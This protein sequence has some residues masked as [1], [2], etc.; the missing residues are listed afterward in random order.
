MPYKHHSVSF[1]VFRYKSVHLKEQGCASQQS[2]WHILVFL[3]F[4]NLYEYL[5]LI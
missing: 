2:V 1:C 5:N 4:G 3:G